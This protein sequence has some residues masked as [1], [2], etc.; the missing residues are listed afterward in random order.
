MLSD[1]QQAEPGTYK[2]SDLGGESAQDIAIQRWG[3]ASKWY[4]V[5][6]ANGLT[7]ATQKIGHGTVITLPNKIIN[8]SNTSDVFKPYSPSEA[9]GNTSPTL[10]D[11]PPPKDPGCGIKQIVM[12]VVII[13]ATIYTAGAA[14]AALAPAAAGAAAGAATGISATFAA[15]SAALTGAAI[16]SVGTAIATVASAAIGGFVGSLAGQVV[17]K[18]LGIVDKIDFTAAA[19]SAGTAA[20]G[21]LVGGALKGVDN[22]QYFEQASGAVKGGEA[23]TKWGYQLGRAAVSNA[24]T[25]GLS[26]AFGQQ[27]KFS[28]DSF[29]FSVANAAVGGSVR[30]AVGGVA[31]PLTSAIS[32]LESTWANTAAQVAIDAVASEGIKALAYGNDYKFDPNQFVGDIIGDSIKSEVLARHSAQTLINQAGKQTDGLLEKQQNQIIPVKGLKED[33]GLLGSYQKNGDIL[34]DQGLLDAAKSG[35]ETAIARLLSVVREEQGHAAAAVIEKELGGQ[36]LPGDEG[37]VLSYLALQGLAGQDKVDFALQ[38]GDETLS[39]TTSGS[40]IGE[41]LDTDYSLGRLLGDSQADGAE[42]R[43]ADLGYWEGKVLNKAIDYAAKLGQWGQALNQKIADNPNAADAVATALAIATPVQTVMMML[44]E[45]TSVYQQ[46]QDKLNG[47]QDEAANWLA[48]TTG[49]DETVIRDAALGLSIGLTLATGAKGLIKRLPGIVD[50]AKDWFARRKSGRVDAPQTQPSQQVADGPACFAAGTLVQ[51]EHGLQ[52]IETIAVGTKVWARCDESYQTTYKTVL[53]R[54]ITP[55]K[56]LRRI[57]IVDAAGQQDYFDATDEHPIWVNDCGWREA[58]ALEP[59]TPLVDY[60]GQGLTVVS[61]QPLPGLHTVYNIEVDD[62]HTY[63]VGTLKAWVHNDARCMENH[64]GTLVLGGR[65]RDTKVNGKQNN[66]ES[67]HPIADDSSDIIA[68]DALAIRMDKDDHIWRT[69]NWG[70]RASSKRFRAK[71]TVLVEQG[72]YDEALQMGID[73]IQL[74]NPGKYDEHIRQMLES[75]P[76]KPNDSIDWSQFKRKKGK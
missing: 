69:G 30:K 24:A 57:T 58:Q 17:G 47:A 54:K 11:A 60:Q 35:D 3:D 5:A 56:T 50:N 71:Q 53:H 14:L 1:K 46:L 48:E 41:V 12:I 68:N 22:L 44:L 8:V 49:R 29:R 6:E 23:L 52:A 76:K 64:A 40:A 51:T 55:E 21:S 67:H 75:A 39:F 61:N 25:Q 74:R 4:I 7:S 10:P 13:I 27:E 73:D 72:K 19:K 31:K 26:M 28:W 32:G 45:R 34:I 42:H 16:S 66:T 36:D 38:I 15:G 20:I 62:F 43:R 18:G 65:H 33:Q 63:H 70:N 9:M 37:A 2:I 59:G